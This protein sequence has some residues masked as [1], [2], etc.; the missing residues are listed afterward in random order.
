MKKLKTIFICLMFLTVFILSNK[1]SHKIRTASQQNKTL[2]EVIKSADFMDFFTNGGGSLSY[3]NYYKWSYS[4]WR[5][6][7]NRTSLE[8]ILFWN[9]G[10]VYDAT[11][12]PKEY[13]YPL[14]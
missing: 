13:P 10:F 9:A 7:P 4:K 1:V 8:K 5:N 2:H 11:N 6:N 3:E 12:A 14:L